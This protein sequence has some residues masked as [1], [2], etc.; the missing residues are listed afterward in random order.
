MNRLDIAISRKNI[1][2]IRIFLGV[3]ADTTIYFTSTLVMLLLLF[4]LNL[5]NDEFTHC[6]SSSICCFSLG[7][8]SI[9]YGEIFFTLF[10]AYCQGTLTDKAQRRIGLPGS[11]AINHFTIDFAIILAYPQSL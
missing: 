5:V 11:E 4:F 10:T 3:E 9:S 2:I 6:L 7:W 1:E 8:T